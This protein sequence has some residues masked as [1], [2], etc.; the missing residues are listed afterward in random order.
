MKREHYI[1]LNW[2]KLFW[3]AGV[4]LL[5]LF[6]SCGKAE[7][8]SCLKGA[9]DYTELM[10]PL[11]SIRHF[12]FNENIKY[13]IYQDEQ[14]KVV[15]KG[16]ANLVEHI[17][18]N[19][20]NDT[21]SVRNNNKCNFLRNNADI[22][23]VEIHYPYL[24]TF[25]MDV[26][27]SVVFENK[28]IGDFL[29]IEMKDGGGSMLLDVDLHRI[30]I[31]V[32]QGAADFTLNGKADEAE[33]KVQNN[34]SANAIRFRPGYVF[35]FQNSTADFFIN[36]DGTSALIIV[37]GTGNVFYENEPGNIEAEGVGSGQ[38]IRL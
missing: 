33:L 34:G 24:N 26:T 28:I 14:R 12:V 30:S 27:D 5:V 32:S 20:V 2:E 36:L 6:Q 19:M 7:E 13:R 11:D 17:E 25:F 35:V 29:G 37:D 1:K 23:E 31:I 4:V 3:F 9:G 15:I 8:R 21:L 22:V 38:I 10:A 16:G 18:V